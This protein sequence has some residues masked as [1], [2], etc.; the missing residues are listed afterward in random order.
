MK[1]VKF[2]LVYIGLFF[3]SEI[4]CAQNA[5]KELERKWYTPDYIKTQYAGNIG[6]I[7]FGAGYYWWKQKAQSDFLYGYVPQ[8]KGNATIHTFTI[9]NTFRLHEFNIKNKYNLSPTIGFTVSFE[10]G[11][12]SYLRIPDRIP[13]GYYVTNSIYGCVNLGL[14]SIFTPKKEHFFSAVEPYFELNTLVDYLFY[15]IKA[16]Q[17]WEDEIWSFSVGFNLHF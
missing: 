6:F 7:S 1:I 9:K 17:Y 5:E 8:F 16:Q 13:D 10:P 14:K 3:C 4:I 11:E 2:I 12:N 15:N